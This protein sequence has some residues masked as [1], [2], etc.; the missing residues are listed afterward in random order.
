M[1]G[2]SGHKGDGEMGVANNSSKSKDFCVSSRAII[3]AVIGIGIC[4]LVAVILT[5]YFGH[6]DYGKSSAVEAKTPPTTTIGKID[7]IGDT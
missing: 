3:A 6:P 5:V 4:V 7:Q 1:N 2:K